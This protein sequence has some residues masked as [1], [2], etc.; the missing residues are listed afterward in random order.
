MQDTAD[1]NA[2]LE[3]AGAFEHSITW[4][5]DIWRA[6]PVDVPTVHAKARA[7]YQTLLEGVT[8]KPGSIQARILLFSRP[9]RRWQNAFVAR[10]PDLGASRRQGLFRLRADDAGCLELC[11]L[12]FAPARA[13]A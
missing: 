5:E 11:R 13:F 6:D 10:A 3:L 9:I 7:K 2:P 1:M 12:L 8:S 4:E